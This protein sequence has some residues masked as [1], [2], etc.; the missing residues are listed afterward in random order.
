MQAK[1]AQGLAPAAYDAQVYDA[2]ISAMLAT[3]HAY[4]SPSTAIVSTPTGGIDAGGNDGGD[5]AMD[6]GPSQMES[7]PTPTR[8]RNGFY[9]INNPAGVKVGT[10]STELQRAVDFIIAGTAM[11]YDG[12]GG[13]TNF[14]SKGDVKSRVVWWQIEG[15]AFVEKKVYD[16]VADTTCPEVVF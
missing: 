9:A 1:Q 10:G 14:D 15:G 7:G 5:L 12:A 16:C 11:D 3:A 4:Y 13:N 2:M 6:A 8:V